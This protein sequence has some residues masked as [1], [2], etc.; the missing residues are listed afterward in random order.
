MSVSRG[1]LAACL[2]L[3]LPANAAADSLTV[4]SKTFT[5]SHVLAEIAAQNLELGGFTVERKQGL[6]GTM[7]L[8]EALQAG[9]IDIYPEYT[10]TLAQTI[11]RRPNADPIELAAAL[12]E[13]DLEIV[14]ELG[15]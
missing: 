10:G 14:A 8:W 9:E 13:R 7:V 12:A 6:G 2:L 3:A 15:F 1:V 11:L 4:G 5:E